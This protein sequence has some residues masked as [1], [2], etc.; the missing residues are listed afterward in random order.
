MNDPIPWWSAM[1]SGNDPNCSY[2]TGLFICAWYVS[3]EFA[4][5][6][7]YAIVCPQLHRLML[8]TLFSRGG[9]SSRSFTTTL[10]RL[11]TCCNNSSFVSQIPGPH[12]RV[13]D[14]PGV[15][16]TNQKGQRWS[17]SQLLLKSS[18]TVVL[19]SSI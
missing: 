15:L 16:E 13:R 7:Y 2:G 1:S 4:I 8:N 14:Y 3:C 17:Q 9:W 18:T 19:V 5:H 12:S 10:R 11:H 6:F